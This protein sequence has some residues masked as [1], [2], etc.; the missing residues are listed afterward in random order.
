MEYI[1]VKPNIIFNSDS[2]M[3]EVI[4]AFVFS[5]CWDKL[6]WQPASKHPQGT[7]VPGVGP[8]GNAVQAATGLWCTGNACPWGAAGETGHPKYWLHPP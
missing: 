4:F 8:L 7:A 1:E 2:G 3:L 5:Y 6:G